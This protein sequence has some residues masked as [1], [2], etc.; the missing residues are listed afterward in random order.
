[1]DSS[2]DLGRVARIVD[3][4]SVWVEEP[5]TMLKMQW[6]QLGWHNGWA[7]QYKDTTGVCS[8]VP[9]VDDSRGRSNW[10]RYRE[11]DVLLTSHTIQMVSDELLKWVSRG[12]LK[13]VLGQAGDRETM[14]RYRA[15][16]RRPK[17]NNIL[18]NQGMLTVEM[19]QRW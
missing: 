6:R 18:K 7:I 3:I 10:L 8:L 15:S 2:S 4:P 14:S 19:L 9:A 16:S 5:N 1:M 13:I 11:A 12:Y 17:G